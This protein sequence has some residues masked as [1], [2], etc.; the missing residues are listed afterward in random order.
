MTDDR[1]E[2]AALAYLDAGRIPRRMVGELLTAGARAVQVEAALHRH[3]VTADGIPGPLTVAAWRAMSAPEGAAQWPARPN[4][5]ADAVRLAG[6][7]GVELLPARAR[8][9][10]LAL[11]APDGTSTPYARWWSRSGAP[12]QAGGR[13]V[14]VHRDLAAH[15][16][17]SLAAARAAAGWAPAHLGGHAA[18]RILGGATAGLSMHALG[19]ALDVDA[20]L[21][22]WGQSIDEC[23]LGQHLAWVE[24]MEAHGWTWGGRWTRTGPDPMHFEWVG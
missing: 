10:W 4:S 1:A 14:W 8:P 22:R 9:G 12:V 13:Y 5:Y 2:R 24:T 15:T 11:D 18:R 6:L 21:N 20:G 23:D 3:E 19:Y 7:A 16:E 17:R